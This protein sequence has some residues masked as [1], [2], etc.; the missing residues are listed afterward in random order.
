MNPPQILLA[1]HWLY[2]QLTALMSI[3]VGGAVFRLHSL[4][5]QAH[6]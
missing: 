6:P 4:Y 2:I 3:R 5:A 1:Y